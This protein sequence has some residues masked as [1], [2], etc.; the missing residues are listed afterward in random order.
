M[1][2]GLDWS[3]F[4]PELTEALA[5]RFF[6]EYGFT[7]FLVQTQFPETF[8]PAAAALVSAQLGLDAVRYL[9]NDQDFGA[10]IQQANEQIAAA[11]PA[12]TRYLDLDFEDESG[13]LTTARARLRAAVGAYTGAT[14]LRIYTSAGYWAATD[15]GNETAM[16]LP[17]RVADWGPPQVAV[18]PRGVLPGRI[19]AKQYGSAELLGI[20]VNVNLL[21]DSLI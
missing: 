4:Q 15:D 8:Q 2:I 13:D 9:Y 18:L 21:E 20:T 6:L 19:D 7:R 16:F 11:A 17:F 3:N 12:K 10:Q 1:H 5:S 14:P